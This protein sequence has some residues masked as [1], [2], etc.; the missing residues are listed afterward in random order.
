M[1]KARY[2][3][4][5]TTMEFKSGNTAEEMQENAPEETQP[6]KDAFQLGSHF[7]LFYKKKK[8]PHRSGK[9]ALGQ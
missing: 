8:T 4:V 5:R 1:E 9:F 3:L 6:F 2:I 7:A